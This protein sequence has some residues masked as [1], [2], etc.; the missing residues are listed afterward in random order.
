MVIAGDLSTEEA[1]KRLIDGL[2][3]TYGRIDVLVNNAGVGW[4]YGITNP[5]SMAALR[6]HARV[7]GGRDEDQPASRTST[8]RASPFSR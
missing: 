4:E 2:V 1:C 7:V 5:G 6:D 8:A 3:E